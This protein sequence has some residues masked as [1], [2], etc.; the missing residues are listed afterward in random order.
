MLF[1]Q[2]H[3][4]LQQQVCLS[5]N[6]FTTLGAVNS[7]PAVDK[8]R[9]F[10]GSDESY[11]ATADVKTGEALLRFEKTDRVSTKLANAYGSSMQQGITMS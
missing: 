6:K 8:G 7:S 2:P 11:L 3:P 1:G 4:T 10:F 5:S 9:V